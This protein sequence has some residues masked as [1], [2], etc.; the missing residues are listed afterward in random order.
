MNKSQLISAIAES[1]G[2]TLSQAEVTL[3]T[4]L[5]G[6]GST[7]TKGD[8]VTLVGFGKFGVKNRAAREVRNPNTGA[9]LTLDPTIVPFFKAGKNLKDLVDSKE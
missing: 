7:L 8:S 6:I 1:A 5:E 2:M 3:S 4:A 9:K